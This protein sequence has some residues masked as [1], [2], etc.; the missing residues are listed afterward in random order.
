MATTPN[1]GWVMPDPTDFVTSLPADFEIFGDAVDLTLDTIETKLD[2]ITTEGDLIVGDASGDPVRLPVGAAGEVLTSDGDTVSFVAPS[3]GSLTLLN[4]G[5]TTL[6]GSFVEIT[7][8]PSTFNHLYILIRN[9]LPA[10]DNRR[11]R[12]RTN[13]TTSN[14]M[15]INQ[16][17]PQSLL[18]GDA[19]W[20]IIPVSDDTVS[21][22]IFAGYISDYAN[23]TT[24]KVLF[25]SFGFSTN[26]TDDTRINYKA[27]RF[28]VCNNTTAITTLRFFAN[29]GNMT[30]GTV[31]VYG[32]K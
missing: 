4:T 16:G 23:T 12:M 19:S 7:S 27:S 9:F 21:T 2:V 28:E 11:L 20:E 5:G 32:V 22:S 18:G 31:F 3:S 17:D 25:P 6:T 24:I 10:T 8:I 30:S 29:I 13:V 15:T 1:Y 26:P 14:Y